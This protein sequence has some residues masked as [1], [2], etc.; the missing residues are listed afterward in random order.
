M[1]DSHCHIETMENPGGVL[2]EALKRR[3][4][5]VVTSPQDMKEAESAFG[6]QEKYPD[7]LFVCLGFHPT[8]LGSYSSDYVENYI[9]FIKTNRN[10][11]VGIGEVGL[12]WYWVKDETKRNESKTAFV[13]FIHLAQELELPLVIHCREA[14]EDVFSILKENNA[15][16]VMMHCFSGTEEHLRTV[17]SRGYFIS[18]ATNV[19]YTKKHPRLAEQTPLE[20]MLP[21][22]DSPFLNPSDPKKPE[23]RPWNILESAKVIG[24]MK[25]VSPEHIIEVT[26]ENARRFFGLGKK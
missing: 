19:C 4:K 7:F 9:S 13:R 20:Q 2:E 3:M 6:L 16:R 25:N 23:N 10:R 15:T 12:D 14:Y 8:G 24:K 26:A 22:T 1:I 18:L 21:E 17:L 5:A 11:I